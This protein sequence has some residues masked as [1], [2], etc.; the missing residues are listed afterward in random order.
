MGVAYQRSCWASIALR[1]EVQSGRKAPSDGPDQVP[2][3]AA[4][5]FAGKGREDP[6]LNHGGLSRCGKQTKIDIYL[7]TGLGHASFLPT[8]I[9]AGAA[10][11]SRQRFRPVSEKRCLPGDEFLGDSQHFEDFQSMCQR[12]D[13]CI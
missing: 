7:V 6:S 2:E 5:Q 12:A 1:R 3:R 10:S 8:A 13:L 9:G 11:R 4:E